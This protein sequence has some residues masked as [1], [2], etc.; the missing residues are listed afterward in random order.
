MRIR[1]RGDKA[2]GT[3]QDVASRLPEAALVAQ[4]SSNGCITRASA[5]S[6]G[7]AGSYAYIRTGK[8][9]EK[10]REREREEGKKDRTR[11]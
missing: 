1:G 8:S 2:E 4:R 11:G 9:R 5:H 6:D 7:F 3:R 10:E